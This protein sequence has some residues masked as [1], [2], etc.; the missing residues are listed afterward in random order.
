MVCR[1]ISNTEPANF[2][3]QFLYRAAWNALNFQVRT[4]K[5]GY[6]SIVGCGTELCFCGV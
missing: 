5:F 1:E 6:S 2:P 3:L 4:S